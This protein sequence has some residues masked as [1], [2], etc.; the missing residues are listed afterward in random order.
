MH[1][2]WFVS[3][4]MVFVGGAIG[5]LIRSVRGRY[6]V[7]TTEKHA[8]SMLEGAEQQADVVRKEGAIH[9]KAEV[10]K[11]KEEFNKTTRARREELAALEERI[12]QRETNLERKVS[13]IEK[14]EHILDEKLSDV[15]SEQQQLKQQSEELD[16]AISEER[17][18]LQ[19]VSRMTQDEARETLL[20]K[21]EKEVHGEM[22]ALVRRQ[23]DQ[24]RESS[25]RE[26]Q[27]IVAL[28]V[29][30][31]SANQAS[32]MMT[33][34]VALPNDEMKGR[35]IGRDGRNIRTIEAVTGVNVLIDD[36]PE[37]VVISGF[38]PV[39]REIA[40]Q[41]LERLVA[42]GRIHP[43]RIEEVVAKVQEDIEET[44]RAAGEEAAFNGGVQGL[45][46]EL[47]RM[48][49]RL[50]FRSSYAQNV[51]QHSLEV[52][53]L[54]G[55]MAAEMGLDSALAKRIGLFHDIGKALDYE[56]E[57]SH[58]VIGADFLKRHAEPQVVLNAVAAHHE[59]VEAKS[60]YAVLAVAADSISG[61][62][63]GARTETTDLYVKRLERLEGIANEFAGVE[64]SYAIQAGREVRVIVSPESIDDNE[65]VLM[66]RD[67][68]TKIESEL[69]YPGQI[70]V[71]VVRET[72]CVEYA[73]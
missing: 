20:S 11:A 43:A 48:L 14:K 73:K 22:A 44:V 35:I 5:Y 25:E 27:K 23:L 12:G 24:A 28:A 71:T 33:S 10:L 60:P 61:S 8:K 42:D 19:R 36:T 38:D 53:H 55:I 21:L 68:A 56:V 3:I 26:A 52:A 59:E 50:K 34:T 72:R 65:A 13:M 29:Q 17:D 67:I 69:Q 57:G 7:D 1:P 66:A 15:E 40:R 6:L 45:D 41:A 18:M 32:E 4:G 58:A 16:K 37:A 39:R 63:L 62:R 49:G 46:P 54:M 30:R 64:K 31:H 9:A 47:S 51:L 70:R 2:A